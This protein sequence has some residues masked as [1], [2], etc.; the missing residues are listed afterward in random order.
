MRVLP[1]TVSETVLP[2]TPILRRSRRLLEKNSEGNRLIPASACAE[3]KLQ[4]LHWEGA[5]QP[6]ISKSESADQTINRHSDGFSIVNLQL[7]SLASGATDII[8]VAIGGLLVT[9]CC[10]YRA[11]NN[12]KCQ[13]HHH[14]LLK[15]IFGR[16]VFRRKPQVGQNQCGRMILTYRAP[17]GTALPMGDGRVH[18]LSVHLPCQIPLSQ[19][20]L[21]SSWRAS[22]W[23][24][25]TF[26]PRLPSSQLSASRAVLLWS[27][28]LSAIRGSALSGAARHLLRQVHRD[29]G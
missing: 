15:T 1:P 27:A 2:E 18:Q 13:E 4:K 3:V 26:L 7:A 21:G 24:P 19:P 23:S 6:G 17:A 29:P 28:W 22:T 14:Q 20:Y 8:A 9:F 12:R 11:S 25:A 5:S 10:Y 16:V